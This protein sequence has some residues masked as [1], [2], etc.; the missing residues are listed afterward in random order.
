MVRINAGVMG[1]KLLGYWC[2]GYPFW[3]PGPPI[4][5]PN[6]ATSIGAQ[7]RNRFSVGVIGLR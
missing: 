2:M 7:I 6:I 5:L 3:G 1:S 4:L